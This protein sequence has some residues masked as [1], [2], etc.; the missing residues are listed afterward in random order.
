MLRRVVWFAAVLVA[1][2]FVFVPGAPARASATLNASW[3][4][5]YYAD[6]SGVFAGSQCLNFTF[7]QRKNGV[8][9]GTWASPSLPGWAGGWVQKGE[10]FSWFGSYKLDGA[11]VATFDAGDFI[12]P[13]IGAESS[14]GAYT[15]SSGV[16]VFTGAATLTQVKNCNDVPVHLNGAPLHAAP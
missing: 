12:S 7:V 15:A 14:A 10:H 3:L 1:C 5:T 8:V 11:A 9:S 16:P 6:P 4:V 2:V 13:T